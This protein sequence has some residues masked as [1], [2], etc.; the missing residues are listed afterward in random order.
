MRP[1][2][3]ICSFFISAVSFSQNIGVNL[4]PSISFPGIK[5]SIGEDHFF[6]LR[7]G[8]SFEKE[9]FKR[10]KIEIGL[11]YQYAVKNFSNFICLASPDI[12]CPDNFTYRYNYLEIPVNFKTRLGIFEEKR[13]TYLVTG[14]AFN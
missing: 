12:P 8:V 1:I 11:A 7:S 6:S 4:A 13:N 14:Y 9:I 5:E 3:F 10:N 2:I